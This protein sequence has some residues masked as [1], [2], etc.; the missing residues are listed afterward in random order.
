MF[1]AVDSSDDELES[2]DDDDECLSESG[3]RPLDASLEI[4]NTK[5]KSPKSKKL[6]REEKLAPCTEAPSPP[7]ESR[8]SE[9]HYLE[10]TGS[11]SINR[12]TNETEKRD[13]IVLISYRI[14]KDDSS[15]IQIALIVYQNNSTN[16]KTRRNLM[17][18]FQE[19]TSELD[20][21][22][23]STASRCRSTIKNKKGHDEV[24]IKTSTESTPSKAMKRPMSSKASLR[25]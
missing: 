12:Q 19:K 17:T 14:S 10:A 24:A 15:N 9:L 18:E 3:I 21:P 6:R 1:E 25:F 2:D 5:Q 11:V 4:K 23:T 20:S 16:P 8:F 7:A 22:S 13:C